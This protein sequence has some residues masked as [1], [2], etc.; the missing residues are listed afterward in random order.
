MA[1]GAV[2]EATSEDLDLLD[3]TRKIDE[4]AGNIPMKSPILTDYH[5][6]LVK[7]LETILGEPFGLFP[8]QSCV[9]TKFRKLQLF[10]LLTSMKLFKSEVI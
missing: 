6:R 2:Q 9:A 7:S 3:K 4:I 5:N 10:E 1:S 8:L